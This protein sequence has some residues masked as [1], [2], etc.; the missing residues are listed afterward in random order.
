VT[1]ASGSTYRPP[2]DQTSLISARRAGGSVSFHMAMYFSASSV[3]SDMLV[4]LS[5]GGR[6]CCPA[7]IRASGR[8]RRGSITPQVTAHRVGQRPGGPSPLSSVSGDRMLDGLI[9]A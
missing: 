3:K 7:V 9:G 4:L 2:E 8:S 1:A 6:A 5:G